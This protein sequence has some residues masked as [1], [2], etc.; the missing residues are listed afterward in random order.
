[1]LALA[2][3]A[4]AATVQVLHVLDE[5]DCYVAAEHLALLHP[6]PRHRDG[7]LMARAEARRLLMPTSWPRSSHST[8]K[9]HGRT[10][11]PRERR[12]KR[13]AR[14]KCSTQRHWVMLLLNTCVLENIPAST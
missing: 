5:A 8:W 2:L 13:R 7:S 1:M 14:S 10:A 12:Q 11:A 3:R 9:R 6:S 4:A